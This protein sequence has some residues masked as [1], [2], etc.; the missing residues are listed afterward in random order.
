MSIKRYKKQ[1]SSWEH[2]LF[3]RYFD[4]FKGNNKVV[5]SS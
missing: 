2:T 5:L 3:E 4:N 1:L